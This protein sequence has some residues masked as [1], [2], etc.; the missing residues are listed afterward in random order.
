MKG[1]KGGMKGKKGGIKGKNR[2][3][4]VKRSVLEAVR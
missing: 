3:G 4:A 2:V 1:N